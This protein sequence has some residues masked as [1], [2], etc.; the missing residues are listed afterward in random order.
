ML[1]LII[2]SGLC[3]VGNL[4]RDSLM[5]F[6]IIPLTFYLLTGT[7]AL[8]FGFGYLF[9]I[10]RVIKHQCDKS[11]FNLEKLMFRIGLF[12]LLYTVP[13]ACVLG[14][15]F[16]QYQNSS[17]WFLKA[18]GIPCKLVPVE[19]SISHESRH[20]F[21]D[22]SNFVDYVPPSDELIISEPATDFGAYSFSDLRSHYEEAVNSE[23]YSLDAKQDRRFRYRSVKERE[24]ANAKTRV[25]SKTVS[26]SAEYM[27]HFTA[28]HEQKNT[29]AGNLHP[30]QASILD[31]SLQQSIASLP[32][33]AIK[34]FMS[35]L[36][37]IASGMWI[38][39]AKTVVSWRKFCYGLRYIEVC[40]ALKK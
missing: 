24:L 18:Q 28:S 27:S 3:Y 9:K 33:F 17:E 37:G 26:D 31:C 2:F 14:A 39:S 12:S 1:R 6:V 5:Y 36:A 20:G 13:A 11:A 21:K 32:I 19:S 10:R 7:V 8:T 4:D 29:A 16:Y 23:A 22:Y 25:L 35:L 15:N 30:H 40:F 38:W 34:I